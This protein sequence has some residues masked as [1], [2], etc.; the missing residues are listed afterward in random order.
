MAWALSL[1]FLLAQAIFEPSLFSLWIPLHFLNIVILHLFAYEDGT[2]R[3][4]WNV[5]M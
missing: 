2:D 4:F 3:V 5:G 1:S